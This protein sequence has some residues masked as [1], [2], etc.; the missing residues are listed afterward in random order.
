MTFHTTTDYSAAPHTYTICY[1]DAQATNSRWIDGTLIYVAWDWQWT[2][3][4][5]HVNVSLLVGGWPGTVA[6]PS[7][8]SA[9]LALYAIDYYAP[10]A[11][12]TLP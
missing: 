8:Y 5:A 3:P 12:R 9:T 1:D 7:T 2:G 11:A 6:A 10:N 4:L